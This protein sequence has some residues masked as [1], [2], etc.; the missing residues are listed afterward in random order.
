M[1][2]L[3]S[4]Q[5]CCHVKEQLRERDCCRG[6]GA[7]EKLSIAHNELSD[8]GSALAALS[9]LQARRTLPHPSRIPLPVCLSDDLVAS[10]PEPT[11]HTRSGVSMPFQNLG[12]QEPRDPNQ[13]FWPTRLPT[14]DEHGF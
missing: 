8:L 11:H 5:C 1:A 14:E 7:L 4:L 12:C 10:P 2:S 6:C 13:L 9:Q 3:G